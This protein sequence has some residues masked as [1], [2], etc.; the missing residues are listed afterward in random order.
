M[1]AVVAQTG[2]GNPVLVR[3]PR[4]IIG[5]YGLGQTLTAPF[6]CVCR[7]SVSDHR[8]PGQSID[9]NCW[10]QGLER[11]A[12]RVVQ[13]SGR[14]LTDSQF[15]AFVTKETGDGGND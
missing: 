4:R 9:E 11:L 15:V 5:R 6:L 3:L 12:E 13:W 1:D 8:F 7:E 10:I 14:H 2:S